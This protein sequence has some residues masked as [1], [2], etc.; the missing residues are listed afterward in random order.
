M[1]GVGDDSTSLSPLPPPARGGGVA[2]LIAGG[3]GSGR[4]PVTPGSAGSAVAILLGWGLMGAGAWALPAAAAVASLGGVWAIRR[5]RVE[6]DPGWVV[7]DEVAGQ[8]V[9]L[10]G[11]ARPTPLGMG[12]AFLLFRLLDITKPGPVGWADRQQGAAAVVADDLI[13]GGLTAGIL[14]AVRSRWPAIFG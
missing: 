13:A 14:W 8:F 5:A 10:L 11:L 9:A 2:R 4:V 3:F 1:A 7:I 6:G 12:A